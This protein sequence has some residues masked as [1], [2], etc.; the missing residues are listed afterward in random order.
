MSNA[1][2]LDKTLLFKALEWFVPY[3]RQKL[4][5]PI[6]SLFPDYLLPRSIRDVLD[7]TTAIGRVLSPWKVDPVSPEQFGKDLAKDQAI[8][9]SLLKQVIILYRRHRAADT[10]DMKEKTFNLELTETLEQE[11]KTLDAL[12]NAEWF[13]KI[14]TVRLPRLKDFLPV[15]LIETATG[16][17]N[18]FLARQYDQKFSILQTPALF[19]TDLA[20]FR[21]RCE[22]RD[23]PLAVA[24]LDIDHFKKFNTT[25]TETKVDRNLLPLFL[26]AV[27]AHVFHHGYAYQEGGDEIVILLPSLSRSLAI[28][29]FDELR[30]KLNAL[31]YPDIKEKTTVSIGISII[32]PDCPQTDRE[33]RDASSQ[34]KKFAK[35]NGRNCIATY[36]GARLVQQE[37]EVVKP[38]VT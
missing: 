28:A 2:L 38:S 37:L 27:E 5:S 23:A 32:D 7:G 9:L 12:V 17:R 11:V 6:E 14:A 4:V 21:A 22:E 26:Q 20:V 10:E 29:F 15:Q 31:E 24:F 8:Q 19:L 25:Y 35:E 36:K 33:L 18:P 34:A 3:F 1:A 30:R 13:E 16:N